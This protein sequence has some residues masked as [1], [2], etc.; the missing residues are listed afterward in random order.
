MNKSEQLLSAFAEHYF[1]KE[2][3][4]DD[5]WFTPPGET[6][7]E[8]ADLIINLG[9]YIIAIQ[10]KSRESSKQT[11]DLKREEKWLAENCKLAKKQVKKT[12]ER[13]EAGEL[14]QFKNK[15]G[16]YA[17]F[18]KSAE[19]IPLVV[20]DN[21]YI[22]KY[23]HLLRKHKEGSISVNCM[24]FPD[25]R[26]M[27]KVLCSPIEIVEYLKYRHDFFSESGDA[28][29]LIH[30]G[31]KNIVMVKPQHK[32]SLV[33]QYLANQYDQKEMMEFNSYL[34]PFRFFLQCLPRHITEK[35][36][37]N[38]DYRILQFLAHLDRK[39]IY[40]FMSRLNRT[41]DDAQKGLAG[42][43]YSLR[44]ISNEY[45]I[46]FVA[47]RMYTSDYLLK[48]VRKTAD[49]KVLLQVG[50]IWVDDENFKIDFL[51]REI[52]ENVEK[53]KSCKWLRSMLQWLR[54]SG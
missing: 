10:L 17:V 9:D 51:F 13:I 18:D 46:L 21:D 5:L 23:H 41:K 11:H 26:E 39:E 24:S 3:V 40:A 27:C 52:P 30:L 25:F 6:K 48:I 15:R 29:V 32:E 20:F 35:S 4:H 34:K 33:H 1:Y 8:L 36:S 37:E 16:D 50:V 44:P 49:V 14:P 31:K 12:L 19:V 54:R 2:F 45:A 22:Q 28:D 38:G 43:L 53:E 7:V 42:I 47:G